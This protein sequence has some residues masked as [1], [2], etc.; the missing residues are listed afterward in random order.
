MIRGTL[1]PEQ[2]DPL[3]SVPL[4]RRFPNLRTAMDSEQMQPHLQRLLFDS[5]DLLV[6]AC[7]RP[8][9]ELSDGAVSL[10]Y[11]LR[12]RTPSGDVQRV[13]VLGTMPAGLMAAGDKLGLALTVFPVTASLPTLVEATDATLMTA[14]LRQLVEDERISVRSVELVVFR[15][16]RG[17]VL[18]YTLDSYPHPIVYGK[19]G[20]TAYSPELVRRALDDLASRTAARQGA[21]LRFP[22]VLGHSRRLELSLAA[23]VP[24]SRPDLGAP[25]QAEQAVDAA[26]EAAAALHS[27]EIAVGAHRTAADEIDR[28]RQSVDLIRADAEELAE[29]LGEVLDSLK[30]TAATTKPESRVFSHGDFTPSQLL[31]D[32]STTGILDFD[33]ICQAEPALDL[34]RFLAYLRFGLEKRGTANAASLTAR[35]L[36]AYRGTRRHLAPEARVHLYEVAS[37]VRMAARSWLQLKPARLR[38]VCKALQGLQD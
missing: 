30:A 33:K 17:C 3:T 20:Y 7:G 31:L 21:R 10:Q 16:G 29:W 9:A 26:A 1:R 24:G 11:P 37:L 5:R 14:V 6:E 23:E 27:S 8:K 12:V 35:F 13:L 36:E 25:L 34:G 19:V 22:R 28:A 38:V 32:G 15:R 18:R 4:N 2:L